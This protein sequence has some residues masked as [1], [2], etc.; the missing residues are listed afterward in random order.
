MLCAHSSVAAF[1]KFFSVETVCGQYAETP[2]SI[3]QGTMVFQ[4]ILY[5]KR[6]VTQDA[7]SSAAATSV[8]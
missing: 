2:W 5:R 8:W 1:L 7:L 6:G 4:K 3:G